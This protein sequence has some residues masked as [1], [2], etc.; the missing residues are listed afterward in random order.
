MPG[1]STLVTVV[2]C[3]LVGCLVGEAASTKG[4]HGDADELQVPKFLGT[5][6]GVAVASDN[7]ELLALMHKVNSS[8]YHVEEGANGTVVIHGASFMMGMCIRETKHFNLFAKEKILIPFVPDNSSQPF[9][10]FVG[11][12]NATYRFLKIKYES[13]SVMQQYGYRNGTRESILY[14]LARSRTLPQQVITEFNAFTV[15]IGL[16]KE[17]TVV[18]PNSVLCLIK[19]PRKPVKEKDSKEAKMGGN[20]DSSVRH[21]PQPDKR[22]KRDAMVRPRRA[23]MPE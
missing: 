20:H 10:D 14:L 17:T 2:T 13:Y 18:V 1:Q 8:V 23:A 12:T 6:Y 5:W 19:E 21:V 7:S 15:G 4:S 11:D 3:V 22:L 9:S 16:D